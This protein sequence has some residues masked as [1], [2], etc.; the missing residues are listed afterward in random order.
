M[1]EQP[2][3]DGDQGG[4]DGQPTGG[5]PQRGQPQGSQP[6]GSQPQGGQPR[7][8]QP[9]GRQPAGRQPQGQ[10]AAGAAGGHPPRQTASQTLGYEQQ[11]L[12]EFARFGA[13]LYGITALG[14]F[15]T[16]F[17]VLSLAGNQSTAGGANFSGFGLAGEELFVSAVSSYNLILTLTPLIAVAIAFYYYRDTSV[18]G[19]SYTPALVA[20]V[21]G[22]ALATVVLLLF[23]TVFAP[24][25]FDVSFG[26]ELTAIIGGLIGTA[27]TAGL[28]GYVFDEFL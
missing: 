28:V 21:A 10:P 20:T 4:Q 24:G 9:Q 23:M 18:S 27:V 17:L 5:Q 19:P 8:G 14:L 11:Q 16:Q 2:D 22:T 26:D 25:G 3:D 15:V 6:R 13:L 7:G 12:V 1:S